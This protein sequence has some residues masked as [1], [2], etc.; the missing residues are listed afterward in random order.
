MGGEDGG[1]GRV[2]GGGNPYLRRPA[3]MRSVRTGGAPFGS[4]RRR[5]VAGNPS[6]KCVWAS[7][8]SQL[9]AASRGPWAGGFLPKRFAQK[10]REKLAFG[11][12]FS[13]W[14]PEA[15]QKLDQTPT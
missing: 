12:S 6:R 5:R 13:F 2:R 4:R 3:T 7:D 9:S 14:R 15:A 8:G 1:D 10:S 11:L